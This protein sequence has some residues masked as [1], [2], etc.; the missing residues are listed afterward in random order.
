MRRRAL[1][2]F[3]ISV[4]LAAVLTIGLEFAHSL[5]D[6][7]TEPLDRLIGLETAV[8]TL[9]GLLV[10]ALIVFLYAV[11]NR[12]WLAG[13]LVTLFVFFI[14]FADY[15]KMR[16]RGEPLFVTDAVHLS[17]FGF[18]AETVGIGTTLAAVAVLLAI[19]AIFWGV[20]HYSSRLRPLPAPPATSGNLRRGALIRLA[21]GAAAAL[22][23]FSAATFNQPHNVTRQLYEA[24]DIRWAPWNQAQNYADNGFIAGLLYN[25]PVSPMEEPPGYSQAAVEDL[26]Q[27]Y[28]AVA[29]DLNATRDPAALADTNVVL[30]LSESLSDPLR[31]PGIT[32]AEDP[33]PYLRSLMASNPS[34]TMLTSGLGGG[35][36]N[37]E[38]EVITGMS[39]ANM[40]PQIHSP[41]QL[42]VAQSEE[43]PSFQRTFGPPA[44]ETLTVHP[45]LETFYRR[46]DVYPALGFA[47]SKFL[48]TM[49]HTG[50][51]Q[52]DRF[53]SDESLY[54]EVLEELRANEEPLFMNVVSMQNHGPQQG[55][56]NPIQVTGP[57]NIKET[58]KAGQYLRG[59]K[60]SDDALR[61]LV[62]DVSTLEERTI[63]LLYGDHLPTVWPE[64]VNQAS[65]TTGSYETPW[66]VFA[67]FPTQ[68]N[69]TPTLGPNQLVNQLID[70]AGAQHTPWTALLHELASE[71]PA[72]QSSAWLDAAGLPT[73]EEWLSERARQLLADYRLAQYD[74]VVGEGWGTQALYTTF[75]TGG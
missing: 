36:A 11:T 23:I 9:G 56:A 32:V 41:Y 74:M 73:S 40:R 63:V 4:A 43:F 14:G 13:G 69:S 55:Y 24:T 38:F 67:N 17:Q 45:Y 48:D 47:R 54:A 35:T 7:W 68:I 29:A 75:P 70:A 25:L 16:F 37:V 26:V 50:K 64:S 46:Y 66:V 20:A 3:L 44:R 59:L 49:T 28:T 1:R 2:T 30:I 42:V 5:N 62:A 51:K 39:V 12:M 57:L 10:W 18:L 6:P 65:G 71:L 19:P 52:G 33:L 31:M 60:Y 22:I 15:Q 61:Q 53:V 8:V 72:M 58:E 34:G 27:R 21:A